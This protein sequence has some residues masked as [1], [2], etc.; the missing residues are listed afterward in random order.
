M[1]S[2]LFSFFFFFFSGFCPCVFFCFF[3]FLCFF[4]FVFFFVLPL[5]IDGAPVTGSTGVSPVFELFMTPPTTTTVGD[6]GKVMDA[7]YRRDDRDSRY[8]RKIL[9]HASGRG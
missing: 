6:D 4:F 1:S 9:C 7:S 8:R 5:Y 3:F 2:F